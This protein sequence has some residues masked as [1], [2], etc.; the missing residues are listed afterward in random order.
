[1]AGRTRGAER[2]GEG[3]LRRRPGVGGGLRLAC[4]VGFLIEHLPVWRF[5]SLDFRRAVRRPI[6]YRR[7]RPEGPPSAAP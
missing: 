4:S 6:S 1:M 2:V 3:E 7:A 5:K